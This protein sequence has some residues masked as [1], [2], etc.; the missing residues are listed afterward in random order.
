VVK[1]ASQKNKDEL[2]ISAA[3]REATEVFAVEYAKPKDDP[4]KQTSAQVAAT[5]GNKHGVYISES[6]LRKKKPGEGLERRGPKGAISTIY[7]YLCGAFITY[8][9]LT[10]ASKLPDP[11]ST[12]H[13]K[14]LEK[15]FVNRDAVDQPK[16][17]R[18]LY[19]RLR[20]DNAHD[21]DVGK[22]YFVEPKSDVI[23]L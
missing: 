21:L 9:A 11:T 20:N 23:L 22:E 17:Y 2:D 3:M 5:I 15:V 16:D 10:Q 19:Q 13:Q 8:I 4:T 7:K 14:L 18:T 1:V 12:D 6:T